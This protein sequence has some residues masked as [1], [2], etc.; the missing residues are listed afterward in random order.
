LPFALHLPHCLG[1]NDWQAPGKVLYR[2]IQKIDLPVKAV[3]F[4]LDPIEARLDGCEIIAVAA[5]L[6][7]NM[8]RHQLLTSTS[9]SSM[10][11]RASNSSFVTYAGTLGIQYFPI[12]WA[13]G[14]QV[15]E[16]LR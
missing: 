7:E 4:F 3:E 8:S 12:R 1:D 11:T 5:R 10:P 13:H 2:P 9:R 16:K 15:S 14:S 6:F